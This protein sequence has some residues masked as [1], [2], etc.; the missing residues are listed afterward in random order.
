LASWLNAAFE[1]WG[2]YLALGLVW[3]VTPWMSFGWTN[4][5]RTNQDVLQPRLFSQVGL[6]FLLFLAVS[7]GFG[8]QYL[9]WLAP[10]VV[11]LGWAPAAFFYS[12]SG[13]FLFLVYNYWAQGLP[14]YLADSVNVGDYPG[15]ADHA[16]LICW[17]SVLVALAVSW[18]GVAGPRSA[19]GLNRDLLAR[20]RPG[21]PSNRS[22]THEGPPG[23]ALFQQRSLVWASFSKGARWRIV[24]ALAVACALLWVVPPQSKAPA[25]P[26]GKDERAVRSIN[27]DSYVDLAHRLAYGGRYEDAIRAA[28]EALALQ[29]DSAEARAAISS[30]QTALGSKK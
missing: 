6:A 10:W 12:A 27:A 2:A 13:V 9:A 14:W 16:Q 15:H 29:P 7:A 23:H 8:V 24:G 19:S 18:R 21:R 1:R 4:S 25:P 3:L 20:A 26:V 11:E 28:G 30:A 22:E 17:F 5:E